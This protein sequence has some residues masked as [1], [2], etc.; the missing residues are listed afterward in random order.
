MF[1]LNVLQVMELPECIQN[2]ERVI[3]MWRRGTGFKSTK[4]G[5]VMDG[6]ALISDTINLRAKLDY[7][8]I[9][10]HFV[11]KVT[12]IQLKR[13]STDEVIAE[14]DLDLADYINVELN[15]YN[16]DLDD[17]VPRACE[18]SDSDEEEKQDVAA[19][20]QERKEKSRKSIQ[21]KVQFKSKE[22]KSK[23]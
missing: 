16:I 13:V 15:S 9:G 1:E 3:V 7:D 5:R 17:L 21:V 10:Q 22:D 11:G 8:P 19:Q 14:A 12:Q 6:R 20:P 18:M 2:D 4:E 23:Q